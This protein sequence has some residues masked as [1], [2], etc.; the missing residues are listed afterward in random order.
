MKFYSQFEQDKYLYNNYF[1]NNYNSGYFI[2]IGAHDGITGS[3]T[4]LFEK[5]GWNG[6]CFEPLP[7]VYKKLKIN[8]KCQTRQIALSNTKG[9]EQFFMIEGYSEMLSGLVSNYEQEHIFRINKELEEFKQNYEY[10]EVECSTFDEEVKNIKIDILSIDTE[11]SESKIIQSINFDKYQISF[12][13]FEMNYYNEELINFLNIK[14]FTLIHRT[15]PDLI[16][17]NNNI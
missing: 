14:N 13:I 1:Q 8:R 15:G 17:K 6:I 9:K 4:F 7:S 12:L 10:I 16:Y 3:N 2:D 5:L 11:G